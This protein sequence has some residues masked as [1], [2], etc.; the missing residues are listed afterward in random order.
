[1]DGARAVRSD[2]VTIS[3][4]NV[5]SILGITGLT[6]SDFFDKEKREES[7]EVEALR[8]KNSFLYASE[9][10]LPDVS[11]IE[12]YFRSD[13]IPRVSSYCLSR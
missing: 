1:M 12:R 4:N 2:I 5:L 7:E 11:K 3:K 9:E 6:E 10:A 13:C 8:Y